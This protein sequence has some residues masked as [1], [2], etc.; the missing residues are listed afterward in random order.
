MKNNVSVKPDDSLFL[1]HHKEGRRKIIDLEG[2]R[3]RE[4]R[5]KTIIYEGKSLGAGSEEAPIFN[6]DLDLIGL[7]FVKT[8]QEGVREGVQIQSII[9]DLI[10]RK[11]EGNLEADEILSVIP[12][13]N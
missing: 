9:N 6:S 3:L 5:D 13:Y 7:D 11:N 4:I 2:N 1:I 8:D 12:S 10:K